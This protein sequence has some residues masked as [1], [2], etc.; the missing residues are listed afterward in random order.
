MKFLDDKSKQTKWWNRNYFYA[1]TVA[2]I[3]L[4]IIIYACHLRLSVY[5]GT[6]HWYDTLNFLPT[7]ESFLSCFEHINWMHVLLNMLCFLGVGLY[8]ERK[9]GTFGILVYVL[10]GAYFVGVAV[11]ANNLGSN[12]MGF[13]G[14]NYFLYAVL[15]LDYVFSF[16]KEL[17]NKTNIILG[18]IILAFIYV[19]MCFN[20]GISTFEFKIYPIDLLTNMGHY[21]SFLMGTVVALIIQITRLLAI[22]GKTQ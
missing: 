18:G 15:I 1:G 20:G 3:L 16:R 6:H 9:K 13:S 8:L 12:W 11:T 21:S 4:N 22:R 19:A 7:I 14:V 2:L 5:N 17:R 10:F